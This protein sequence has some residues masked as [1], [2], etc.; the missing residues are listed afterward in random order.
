MLGTMLHAAK[1]VWISCRLSQAELRSGQVKRQTQPLP[2]SA[3]LSWVT[4]LCLLGSLVSVYLA[5]SHYRVH[6]DIGYQ[7]FCALS[8]AINCDTVSQ[9]PY[10]VFGPLPLAVWGLAGYGIFLLLLFV[11]AL[12]P[13]R[14]RRVWPL[15]LLVSTCFNAVSVTLAGV[16]YR[17]IGSYCLLCFLTYAINLILLFSCWIVRRRFDPAPLRLAVMDDLRFLRRHWRWSLP[18]FGVLSALMVVT[19]LTYPQYWHLAPPAPSNAIPAGVNSEGHPWIGAEQPTI[20]IVEFTDYQCFQCRKMHF[21]LR[22]LVGLNPERIRL[23]HRNYPMD[24]EYNP[25]VIEPFH[26]G[27]GKIA[28]LAIHASMV[29]KFWAV[30]DWLL[31]RAPSAEEL[32]LGDLAR[33]TGLSHREL[34]AAVQHEPYIQRLLLDIRQGMLLRITGT[35]SYLINGKVYEGNIPSDVLQTLIN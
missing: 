23:T 2:F 18:P 30:N 25:I 12:P 24:H 34:Q 21:F 20:E 15:C 13:A 14:P 1:N 4:G 9:S 35:P 5:Y 29:G 16:S 3:Y 31:S 19:L 28:L 26:L 10:A 6:T 11:A 8:K 7:S 33:D 17:L 22:E 27:S 32:N